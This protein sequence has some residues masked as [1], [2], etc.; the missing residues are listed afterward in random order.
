M[1]NKAERPWVLIRGAGDL[2][3]GT[4]LRLHRCGFKVLALECADPSAI[5]RK[6]AFCEAVWQGGTTVEGF[7]A[8]VYVTP[9]K[10]YL[11][12]PNP[13]GILAE[14]FTVRKTYDG[15]VEVTDRDVSIAGLSLGKWVLQTGGSFADLT[16]S[17]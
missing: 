3:T 13:I 8:L 10:G 1:Q 12:N 14:Y 15:N 2:A 16:R 9:E 7:A 5:R 17:P 4:I 11:I 6:A